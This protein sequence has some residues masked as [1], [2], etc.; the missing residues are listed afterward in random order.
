MGN[1]A[2]PAPLPGETV[3][4]TTDLI[5]AS[6]PLPQKRIPGDLSFSSSP[7]FIPILAVFENESSLKRAPASRFLFGFH[8]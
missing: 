5:A 4:W 1:R 3:V 6:T 7:P 8:P 2:F